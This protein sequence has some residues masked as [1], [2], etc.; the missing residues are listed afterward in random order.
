MD[1]HFTPYVPDSLAAGCHA[2]MRSGLRCP[3]LLA[4]TKVVTILGIFLL[5]FSFQRY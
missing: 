5:F 4:E 3:W 2:L 1:I